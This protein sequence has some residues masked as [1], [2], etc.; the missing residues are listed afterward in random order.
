MTSTLP[1]PQ[2]VAAEV[3][4]EMGWQHKSVRDLA[5]ALGIEY[6]AAKARYDGAREY[7]L[8]EVP[9]V[10]AWLGVSVGQLTTGIRD[11]DREALVA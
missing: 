10:A 6:R 2:R 1:L 5:G 4:A 8:D 9:V 11:R 7:P 3:R